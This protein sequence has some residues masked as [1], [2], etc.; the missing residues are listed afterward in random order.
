MN[1]S[2]IL[3][4]FSLDQ[5]LLQEE[6]VVSAASRNALCWHRRQWKKSH[7]FSCFRE[8]GAELLA[9]GGMMMGAKKGCIGMKTN[10]WITSW[11]VVCF[12]IS[13]W[14][15]TV[16]WPMGDDDFLR[17]T[18]GAFFYTRESTFWAES[19]YPPPPF[20][21]LW[22]INENEEAIRS[23]EPLISLDLLWIRNLW[24]RVIYILYHPCHVLL[25]QFSTQRNTIA[26]FLWGL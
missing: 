13:R 6:C 20:V 8:R 5:L 22:V 14:Q 7:L 1:I 11:H 23:E 15:P 21:P 25:T 2:S 10:R 18:S 17:W 16:F 9:F 4:I 19:I 3:N 24:P 12:L 26:H